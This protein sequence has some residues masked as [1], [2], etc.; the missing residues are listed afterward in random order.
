MPHSQRFQRRRTCR[1]RL[2]LRPLLIDAPSGAS[3]ALRAIWRGKFSCHAGGALQ[4][5]ILFRNLAGVTEHACSGIY[6]CLGPAAHVDA[7]NSQ[8]EDP[9]ALNFPPSQAMHADSA[10]VPSVRC[11]VR[12]RR[13]YSPKESKWTATFLE[14]TIGVAKGEHLTLL[15]FIHR[16]HRSPRFCVHIIV[17]P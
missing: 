5:A 2:N 7:V 4:Q 1:Q 12:R 9:A 17:P 10:S 16:P 15:H 3:H 6:H 14:K 8:E 11:T 13:T